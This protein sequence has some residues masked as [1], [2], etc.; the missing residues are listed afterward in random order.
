MI[1]RPGPFA[2]SRVLSML[3]VGKAYFTIGKFLLKEARED[4]A[5]HWAIFKDLW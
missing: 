5:V 2:K 4:L 1:G 3:I